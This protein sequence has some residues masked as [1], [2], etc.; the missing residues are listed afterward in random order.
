LACNSNIFLT[1]SLPLITPPP[2]P[3]LEDTDCTGDSLPSQQRL[4]GFTFLPNKEDSKNG[5]GGGS[6]KGNVNKEK[7]DD[8]GLY[9]GSFCWNMM[10]AAAD[11]G[12]Q[13]V[14][15]PTPTLDA[16]LSSSELKGVPWTRRLTTARR[17][18]RL[19]E[20]PILLQSH[21]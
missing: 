18:A 5:G 15:A 1:S 7:E 3:N 20:F 8:N 11:Y 6:N 12:E 21:L 4:H 9:L 17:P 19:S 13:Q 16:S 2:P 10:A 14:T